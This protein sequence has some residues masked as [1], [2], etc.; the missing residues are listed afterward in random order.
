MKTQ[1]F[2]I[3]GR[4]YGTTERAP[5]VSRGDLAYPPGAAFFC[6]LCTELWA[7]CPIEGEPSIVHIS[8]C[9]QHKCGD[10]F[11][12]WSLGSVSPWQV[13]GSLML[14]YDGTWNQSLPLPVLVREFYLHFNHCY[15]QKGTSA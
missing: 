7:Q 12:S 6:P 15:P 3:R 5:M 9:D 10:H 1:H 8:P 4:H 13:P 14:S 11:G 2:F